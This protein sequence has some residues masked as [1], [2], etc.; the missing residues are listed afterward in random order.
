M[1]DFRDEEQAYIE[2]NKILLR[3]YFDL[4]KSR[5]EQGVALFAKLQE[6]SEF[7]LKV[8]TSEIW[9]V[10]E[11]MLHSSYFVSKALT[12]PK[13]R[14]SNLV[15]TERVRFMRKVLIQ[16]GGEAALLCH[17]ARNRVVHIDEDLDT[18]WGKA[19]DAGTKGYVDGTIASRSG[20]M[21]LGDNIISTRELYTDTFTARIFGEDVELPSLSILLEKIAERSARFIE[22][23]L[24]Q[25]AFLQDEA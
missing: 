23:V 8:E 22:N 10:L 16:N 21:F 15:S 2:N 12:E 14:K 4:L 3:L 20:C 19:K 13:G 17:R 11:S 1:S 18:W 7:P 25:E 9:S 24:S 5:A 6:I